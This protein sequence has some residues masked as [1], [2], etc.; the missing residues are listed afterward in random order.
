M[1]AI[2][3]ILK[4]L[5]TRANTPEYFGLFHLIWLGIVVLATVVLC[6]LWKK[7]IIKDVKKTVL[8]TSIILLI[9]GLY[10][11]IVL[12]FDYS[13]GV[14]F[15]YDW[16]NFPWHFLST[17]LCIGVFV[18]LT[19]GSINKHFTSYLA[20]FGFLAG[21]WGFFNKDVFVET[22]GL[23]V[24]SMLCFG[25]MI[26]IA[27][28]L[29]FTK[30]VE[31]KF[32]TF[33]K[34]LPV[35]FMILGIA[36]SFNEVAHLVLPWQNVSMFSISRHFASD[37]PVYSLLH[38]ALLESGGKF[39]ILEYIISILAYSA[40][41]SV[42][43][44]LALLVVMCVKKLATTDFDA[45]YG[46][47]KKSPMSA[48]E[49]QK[50]LD[51]IDNLEKQVANKSNNSFLIRYFQN[52]RV[53]F[54]NNTKGSCGYVAIAMILSYY[55]TVLNDRI[56]PERYD[57]PSKNHYSSPG[58]RKDYPEESINAWTYERYKQFIDQKKNWYLHS[59]LMDLADENGFVADKD[60]DYHFGSNDEKRE[61]VLYDYLKKIAKIPTKN[62]EITYPHLLVGNEWV[63]CTNILYENLN[64]INKPERR[65]YDIR[66]KTYTYAIDD[67]YYAKLNNVFH[68][69]DLIKKYAID[70]I[71]NQGVPVLLGLGE[72]ENVTEKGVTTLKTTEGHAV[73]AYAVTDDEQLICHFGWPTREYSQTAVFDEKQNLYTACLPNSE[74]KNLVYTSAAVINFKNMPHV[75]TNNYQISLGEKTYFYCPDDT[76]TTLTGDVVK[77]Y[78]NWIVSL[79]EN[80]DC[81]LEGYRGTLVPSNNLLRIPGSFDKYKNTVISYAAFK[82]QK[83]IQDVIIPKNVT[84]I[85]S[86]A[87]ENCSSLYAVRIPKSVKTI[88]SSAFKNC[89]KLTMIEYEGTMQEWEK[90]RKND[91]WN[92]KTGNYVVYCSNG[93]LRKNVNAY[94]LIFK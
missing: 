46:E 11:Q 89:G 66:T 87:F 40:L 76:Y 94:D 12:S 85:G 2:Q 39:T 21:L 62:C 55:D 67:F 57:K 38:N 60:G 88:D 82:N 37:T 77:I 79:L 86:N 48:D 83:Y 49:R 70:V 47:E 54:G 30:T 23:N 78:D 20:T 15:N 80:D 31:V 6:I 73:V 17:P 50:L 18:G 58:I 68:C 65:V 8:V 1:E 45:E 35:F 13:T 4:F 51:K 71:R 56:I 59:A 33:F 19:T 7:K 69:S 72:L 52:L 28:F 3:K 42:F 25:S 92:E 41:V 91:D 53:N 5:D 74:Y 29:Y 64:E 43:T 36:I 14:T 32:S 84:Y 10:R 16:N 81:C 27:I 34:S 24:Y 44:I 63:K 61:I 26:V 93:K 22:I 90:I 75:H 9:L